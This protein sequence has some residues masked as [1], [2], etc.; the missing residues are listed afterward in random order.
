MVCNTFLLMATP[1][2]QNGASSVPPLAPFCE[3]PKPS[4]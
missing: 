3:C 1:S 2:T 4:F